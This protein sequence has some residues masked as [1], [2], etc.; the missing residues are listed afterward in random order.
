MKKTYLVLVS[1]FLLSSC[2]AINRT[3]FG[4]TEKDLI[5]QVSV[6]TGCSEDKIV[7]VEKIKNFGNATYSLDVCGKRMI[8]KQVGSVFMTS[9]QADKLLK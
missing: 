2:G 1:A 9:E 6:E 5:K 7:I 3:M 8:Y 4:N